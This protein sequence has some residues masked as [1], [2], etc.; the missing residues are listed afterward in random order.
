MGALIGVAIW[1]VGMGYACVAA[2]MHGPGDTSSG[3]ASIV[4][5]IS[6]ADSA[7]CQQMHRLQ[8]EADLLHSYGLIWS[9]AEEAIYRHEY[10]KNQQTPYEQAD[11]EKALDHSYGMRDSPSVECV[12]TASAP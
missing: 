1:L 8:Q 2:L 11:I 9:D 4:Q 7:R 6:P 3:P 5:Q 12:Q 10:V